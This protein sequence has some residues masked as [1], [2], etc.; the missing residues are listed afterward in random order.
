[1]GFPIFCF[2]KL[3]C[4]DIENVKENV[5]MQQNQKVDEYAQKDTLVVV[6]HVDNA[7]AAEDIVLKLKERD[8]PCN[9]E[10]RSAGID[11]FG[12]AVFVPEQFHDEACVVI[13]DQ[14][15]INQF[16]DFFFDDTPLDKH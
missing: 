9:L 2:G 13:D 8:I 16:D 6:T 11:G 5:M 1:M 14:Q 12:F 3:E 10:D 15:S 7:Y 4:I